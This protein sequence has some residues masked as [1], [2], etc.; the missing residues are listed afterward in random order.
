MY[1]CMHESA[2]DL[3]MLSDFD[4]FKERLDI[5]SRNFVTMST[6]LDFKVRVHI[7]DTALLSPMGFGSLGALGSIYGDEF[8]KVD[9]GKYSKSEMSTLLTEDRELFH[10]YALQDALITLKHVNSMEDFYVSIG[11]RGV[12]L[13][14]SGVGKHYV[15]HEWDRK[16]YRGYQLLGDIPLGNFAVSMTPKL[17]RGVF[18]S[19]YIGLI[20]SSYRGGRNESFMY[21]AAKGR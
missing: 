9:L 11:K 21:G 8:N 18:L 19:K 3:S 10:R 5:I 13:T 14:L 16:G 15:I 17:S 7:R 6:P 12:P 2:A 20:L 1:L 4:I